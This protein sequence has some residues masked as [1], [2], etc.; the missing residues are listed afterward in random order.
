MAVPGLIANVRSRRLLLWLGSGVVLLAPMLVQGAV[1]GQIVPDETLG[2]ERSQVSTEIIRGQPNDQIN[3]GAIR[4]SNLFHSFQEFNVE[5]GRGAYF[6]NSAGIDN[7]FSRVT[8]ENPSNILGVLGTLGAGKADLFFI[9]P[10][11]VLFGPNS[12]LDVDGSLV[13][14][15]SDDIAFG[16]TGVFGT[17]NPE[18]PAQIL[19]V[20]PSAFLFTAIA[21]NT[22]IT[23]QSAFVSPNNPP[24]VNGLRVLD[25]FSLLLLG[26]EI[27]LQQG[28][29]NAAEGR[30]ELLAIGE[31]GS[32]GLTIEGDRLDLAVPA[33]LN[34]SVVSLSQGTIDTGGIQNSATAGGDIQIQG[35]Q[36]TLDN[37]VVVSQ[38]FGDQDNGEISLRGTQV[39]FNN[40]SL[41]TNAYAS[42]DGGD[43]RV[44]ADTLNI[45]DGGGI[46][47]G[48]FFSGSSGD[49]DI[50][51]TG[52][53][54]LSNQVL[55]GSSFLGSP[56]NR[57]DG[58]SGNVF[59]AAG[60][61]DVENSGISSGTTL[62]ESPGSNVIIR[63]ADSINLRGGRLAASSVGASSSGNITIE[64]GNLTLEEKA[65]NLSFISSAVINPAELTRL[66]E[67]DAS[68]YPQ[69]FLDIIRPLLINLDPNSFGQADSGAVSINARDSIQISDGS[70]IETNAFGQASG[71]GL[72]ATADTIEL[73]GFLSR[74][75]SDALFD[76]LGGGNGGDV[77]VSSRAL[78]V[79]D[80]ARISSS[81]QGSGDGGNLNVIV[82]GQAELTGTR[83]FST[84]QGQIKSPSGLFTSSGLF[85]YGL[86]NGDAGALRFEG[87]QLQLSE[88]ATISAAALGL[89]NAGDVVV[90]A[91]TL[92]LTDSDITT[93]AANTS[94]G[95]ITL[96]A[97]SILLFGDSDIRTNSAQNG[98]NILMT[99]D[100]V[101]ALY[102]SDIFASAALGNGG[103]ITIETP[104]F[105]GNAYSSEA[106]EGEQNSALL[107]NNNR[108]DLDATGQVSSGVIS[109]PSDSFIEND[110]AELS[111][112]LV[113]AEQFVA[114]SCVSRAEQDG[115]LVI[116]RA[117]GLP[118]TPQS[119]GVSYPTGPVRTSVE[120]AAEMT[121]G[122]VTEESAPW[123]MGD[124]IVEPQ[125]TYALADGR[126]IL[127]QSC[128]D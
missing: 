45:H 13:V 114:I 33:N 56:L 62:G 87:G 48:G 21:P 53:L 3:G 84:D 81:S 49:V 72:N 102:D 52:T 85:T 94:G 116:T 6:F 59:I 43:I 5:A 104:A 36:V 40:S 15:T 22:G 93:A 75:S 83:I 88:G 16:E 105:F 101:V 99:A 12:F 82:T 29:L 76:V 117:D 18:I 113:N 106:S 9:N 8:G 11:G 96:S 86:G 2:A 51:V 67:I 25:G 112:N 92:S 26:D 68:I 100:T 95:N 123:Q 125:E 20:N 14:T 107:D 34:L 66:V 35:G 58:S 46:T 103:D 98:G 54:S 128:A 127:S 7:I 44:G 78:R 118:E 30:I 79:Q 10:N 110:L 121:T 71:G 39:D 69:A 63:V 115:S 47:T 23:N 90:V 28:T 32:V 57:T 17:T 65:G 60:N 119:T 64:T 27:R 89:G 91:D 19:T 4:G 38:N 31:P 109:T 74:I 42:G 70:S 55:L 37:T 122:A 108:T 61:L 1:Q 41:N 73:T 24:F 80:G 120:T 126:L 50:Q 77:T 124:P 111:G 97:S